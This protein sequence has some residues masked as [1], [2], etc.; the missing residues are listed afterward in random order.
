M[1]TTLLTKLAV[2]SSLASAFA[3]Y[4]PQQEV[5]NFSPEA[6]HVLRRISVRTNDTFT[7]DDVLGAAQ[8]RMILSFVIH[9]LTL[10]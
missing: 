8:V 2:L 5:L 4:I 6:S 1:M 10:P 7:V 3:S 9:T